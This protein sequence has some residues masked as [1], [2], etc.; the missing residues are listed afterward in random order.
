MDFKCIAP[1]VSVGSYA[2]V[3]SEAHTGENIAAAYDNIMDEFED[4]RVAYAIT[5]NASNM[6]K[7]FRTQLV[8][9]GVDEREDDQ[10]DVDDEE[11]M[12]D[13]PLVTTRLSCFAHSLQLC[14]HDALKNRPEMKV[15]PQ[16]G[17]IS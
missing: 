6:K 12:M 2:P 14:I 15:K 3:F 1:L 11:D 16:D 17:I 4:V 7:A 8:E 10:D 5:D 9:Q 13:V